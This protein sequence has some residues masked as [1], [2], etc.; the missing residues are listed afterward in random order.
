MNYESSRLRKIAE[1][2]SGVDILDI[3]YAALPNPY[4]SDL[5][6]IGYDIALPKIKSGYCKEIQGD[7]KE[8]NEKLHDFKFDTVVLGELIEH[9]ENPYDLLRDLHHLLNNEGRIIISTPNP[10]GFP[11][12]FCELLN[13]KRYFYDDGHK[14]YFLPRWAERLIR[15]SGYE[16]ERII[17]VGL[18]LPV[19]GLSTIP[20]PKILSYQ[21]IYVCKSIE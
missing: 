3:G 2:V 17:P 6:C 14:Y 7:V 15:Q 19:P 16:I 5:H 11:V 20:S 4:L 9:M 8:I 12:F 21:L 10:L 1:N 13:I 18:L